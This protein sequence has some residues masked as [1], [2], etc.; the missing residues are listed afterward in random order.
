MQYR[1]REHHHTPGTT[2]DIFDGTHYRHLRG[3]HVQVSGK[4]LSHRYFSDSRD[5]ALGLSTDGFA[6][7]KKR[8]NTAWPLIVFNYNLPPEI[9]FHL[10]HILSLGVIPGP[11]KPIDA[12]SFLWP[13]VQELLQLA[14]GV[15]AY[16]ILLSKIFALRAFLIVVFGDIPAISMIM[17]MKGHNAISPCRMCS[18]LGVRIPGSRATTHY[19]PLDQRNHPDVRNDEGRTQTFDPKCLPRR[20]HTE[21]LAQAAE[22]DGATTI[23]EAEGLAKQYGIKGTPILSFLDSLDFPQSFPYDF[24]H[25]IWE[26]V[27]KNLILHWT[28]EFKG[29]DSGNESYQLSSAIWE[30][31]GEKTVAAGSTIPS[32]YGPRIPNVATEK[33][34]L[35]AEMWS[36]WSL[37]LGP[38]LLRNRF[39]RPKYYRHFILL[40]R[41]LNICLKFEIT[42]SEIDQIQEGFISWVTEYEKCARFTSLLWP[43]LL[44]AFISI[45]YQH[46]PNR[47][48]A[49]PLT[50]HALLHITDSIRVMGP[51]W[52]YWAYPMERYCGRLQ[53]AIQSRRFPYKSLDRYVVESAQLVQVKLIYNLS[54]ELSLQRP[55]GLPTGAYADPSCKSI[56]SHPYVCFSHP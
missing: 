25:L 52:C 21:L 8:R 14:I 41:L 7:F 2:T 19:I 31:V 22:V 17:R 37:Y 39:H 4:K 38:V 40:V 26:N 32:A 46:N 44:T 1:G 54:D 56:D 50:I 48:S 23:A 13:F 55:K 27:V 45:Y 18:I 28:G 6:P 15:R 35:S 36:F 34:L 11:K 10:E 47:L 43:T 49:C 16:D 33:S 5:V 53:L 51:V 12:D 3:R 29:L 9:R 30:A 24:M 20:K 42:D